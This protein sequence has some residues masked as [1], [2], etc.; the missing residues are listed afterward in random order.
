M[1]VYRLEMLFVLLLKAC[2][3][4]QGVRSPLL[5]RQVEALPGEERGRRP[6]HVR[7]LIN[8]NTAG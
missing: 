5:E 1:A 8:T 6:A 7:L 3:R 4:E 2:K